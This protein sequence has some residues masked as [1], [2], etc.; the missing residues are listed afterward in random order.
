MQ[1][2]T[3]DSWLQACSCRYLGQQRHEC[4]EQLPS[5]PGNGR[6]LHLPLY[7]GF[8]RKVGGSGQGLRAAAGDGGGSALRRLRVP[9]PPPRRALLGLGPTPVLLDISAYANIWQGVSKQREAV[10]QLWTLNIPSGARHQSPSGSLRSLSLPSPGAR[11]PP[12]RKSTNT[13]PCAWTRIRSSAWATTM[14]ATSVH[15]TDG[16]TYPSAP[17]RRPSGKPRAAAPLTPRPTTRRCAMVGC[18]ARAARLPRVG[19]ELAPAR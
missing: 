2:P 7:L 14:T 8:A 17:S 6:S 5:S 15:L 12:R 13:V 9:L 19:S 4:P 16:T 10:P 18:H 3:V 11:P 1:R